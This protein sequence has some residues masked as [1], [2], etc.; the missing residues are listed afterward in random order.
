MFTTCTK[1]G[2][3]LL[4]S[5]DI[6]VSR[7]SVL[8]CCTDFTSMG[9]DRIAHLGGSRIGRVHMDSGVRNGLAL[10]KR[11]SMLEIK[12]LLAKYRRCQ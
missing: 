12:T 4:L 9:H 2:A 1:D 8:K 10:Y 6:L 5:D 11:F 3:V 7:M